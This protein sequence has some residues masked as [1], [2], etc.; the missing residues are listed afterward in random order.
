MWRPPMS[1]RCSPT[2]AR[3]WRPCRT[4]ASRSSGM[5]PSS[6][7]C[8]RARTAPRLCSARSPALV[9][10]IEQ[11]PG[12]VPVGLHLCYGDYGHE[13]FKQPESL[14]MQ[15]DLVNALTAAAAR[16]FDAASFTVTQARDDADYFAPLAD[17]QAAPE[18]ELYFALVPYHP[19][20]QPEGTTA[21][22]KANIDAA[23]GCRE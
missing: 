23:L 3:R 6:S 7:A 4:I 14:R 11:V 5:S 15:V 17:L 1:V 21:A 22:E 10:R 16:P 18:T 19:G 2:S 9:R 13:H 8:W 12:D 20:D